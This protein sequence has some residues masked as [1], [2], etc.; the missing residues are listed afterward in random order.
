MVVT[1]GVPY[2]IQ[3]QE[4]PPLIRVTLRGFWT[5]DIFQAYMEECGRVIQG[6]MARHGRFDTL[7]DCND[8]PVQGPD[9]SAA[10]ERLKQMSNATPR[11][12][13]ALFT[14]SALGRL[15]AERLVGNPHSK[16]FANEAAAIEWLALYE[17]ADGLA[18]QTP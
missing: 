13:I 8:F 18:R 16:V 3:T 10:F 6:L 14:R 9:V 15:Q 4:G 12:R 11:N 7:G 5:M 1:G 17:R 2:S